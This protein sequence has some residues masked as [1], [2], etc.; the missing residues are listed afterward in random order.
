MPQSS[1][2][3]S[4]GAGFSL[5]ELMV[6]VAIVGILAAVAVPSYKSYVYRSQVAE[7]ITFLGEIKQRQ[8]AYRAEFGQ[9]CAV[10]GAGFAGQY[11]PVTPSAESVPWDPAAAPIGWRQL[12]AS[13][14]GNTRF[15]YSVAAGPPGT[16]PPGVPGYT[17][18]DFW[19]VSRG[20]G[21]VDGDGVELTLEGY[22][23]ADYVYMGCPDLGTPCASGYE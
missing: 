23:E 20:F 19:F 3:R 6:V 5:I 4:P 2:R 22:S 18:A 10:N 21:D 9:Y 14:A 12:G 11:P 1:R 16:T 15:S 13:P 17:G 8:E 7:G